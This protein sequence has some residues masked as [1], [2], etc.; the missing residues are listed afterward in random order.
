MLV[1]QG[2]IIPASIANFVCE[3]GRGTVWLLAGLVEKAVRHGDV[4]ALIMSA[5]DMRQGM[6]VR[7]MFLHGSSP[8][9]QIQVGELDHLPMQLG[10]D[11][12]I[13]TCRMEV[14]AVIDS[15]RVQAIVVS[16]QDDHRPLQTAQLLLG[17]RNRFIGDPIMIEQI[18]SNE[19]DIDFCCHGAR[20][21]RLKAAV[22]EGTVCLALVRFAITIA[23]QV[24][25]GCM[26]DF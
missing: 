14:V 22:I 15:T 5:R 20:D 6:K 21:D 25:I 9:Y 7:R 23:I 19:Q 3:D 2:N 17:K 13:A 26:Q 12:H 4:P 24:H 1:P 16:W 10:N 11:L 8:H 18:A